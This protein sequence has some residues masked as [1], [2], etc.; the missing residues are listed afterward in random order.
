MIKF[1]YDL[2]EAKTPKIRGPEQ[3]HREQ[4]V[5]EALRSLNGE[6]Q[7]KYTQHFVA[8]RTVVALIVVV[9]LLAHSHIQHNPSHLNCTLF[10]VKIPSNANFKVKG[11]PQNRRLSC[12]GHPRRRNTQE[13][14]PRTRRRKLRRITNQYLRRY[15]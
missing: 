11:R 14:P 7:G 10:S 12:C 9:A 4:E 13:N 2:G 3:E 1:M 5:R 15:T 6:Q 8:L